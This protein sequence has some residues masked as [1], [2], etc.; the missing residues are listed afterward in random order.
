MAT[1]EMSLYE[2][3]AA[4]FLFAHINPVDVTNETHIRNWMDYL[5]YFLLSVKKLDENIAIP[6][7]YRLCGAPIEEIVR[8]MGKH[9]RCVPPKEGSTGWVER[10]GPEYVGYANLLL[11]RF[12]DLT[13]Y[14]VDTPKWTVQRHHA[15]S[16]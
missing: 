13:T 12:N 5:S 7:S 11:K 14:R 16:L 10:W 2:Y 3:Y 1:Q 6:D 9:R 8:E 15:W 4:L